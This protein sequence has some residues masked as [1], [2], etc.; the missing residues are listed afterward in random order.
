[1]DKISLK[2]FLLRQPSFPET[3]DS[4]GFY[5]DLSN[6]LLDSVSI[7]SFSTG[8]PDGVARRIALTLTDYMRD[9][10]ADAGLWRTFVDEN[11]RLY[12][13]S[14]PFH[15]IPEEYI[16]YELNREDVRFLVWYVVAMLWEERRLIYPHDQE[17]I[18]YADRCFDVLESE[19]D[20][21][22]VPE[23][24]NSWRGLELNDPDDAR[25]IFH[26]GNWLFLHS[27]LLT[28]AFA[29]SLREVLSE[30]SPEDK[31]SASRLNARLEE[32]MMQDTTGPL[33]LFTHEWVSLLLEGK[34][35][36]RDEIKPSRVHPY[37]EAFMNATDGRD[38]KFFDSYES[39]NRFFIEGLGWEPDVEH[40]AQAKGA[41]DYILMVTRDKGM[42]MA[43]DIARCVKAPG[44]LMFDEQYAHDHSLELLTE[45]GC[46]P[47]DL[48]RKIFDSDWLPYAHFPENE[49]FRLVHDNR[50]FI[51]RCFLQ[52]YYR[53]D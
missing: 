30:F 23:C 18:E 8:M 29:M 52:I 40:L 12:G 33:A 32:A 2:E 6:K 28:P 4:D 9:I 19:Y 31:D 38:I 42:L 43:R 21:A 11:R 51:A 7:L 1:M 41:H 46:C 5:L 24:F 47:G 14:V 17:L 3:T 15:D 20:D 13:Y 53:G 26:L 10:V 25:Q 50:D 45:R 49:D 22:P 35:A 27:Y 34:I 48:L 36:R 16:D 44:N 39:M 37:Y